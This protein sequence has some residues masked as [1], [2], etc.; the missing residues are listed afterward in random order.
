MNILL[1]HLKAGKFGHFFEGNEFNNATSFLYT[2]LTSAVIDNADRFVIKT[3]HFEWY[4]NDI[5]IGQYLGRTAPEPKPSYNANLHKILERDE[6]V[7]RYVIIEMETP[8][9]TIV[10]FKN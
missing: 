9:K 5:Q 4:K 6:I 7:R 3:T 2:A 8:E 1:E 10:H